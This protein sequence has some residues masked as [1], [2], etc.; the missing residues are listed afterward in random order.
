MISYGINYNGTIITEK[1]RAEGLEQPTYYWKPSI[2]VC[3]L[4]F[5][6]GDLFPRWKNQLLVGSLK[7]EELQL[8]DV[9]SDRV[10]YQ[11]TLIKNAGRV[12]DV[13]TGPDGAIYVVLNRPG[14]VLQLT[15]ATPAPEM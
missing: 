14:T 8:L 12:R 4:D 15:P 2:A 6:R 1:V 3:G 11:Q 10:M 13:A 9:E 5:Y 7:F